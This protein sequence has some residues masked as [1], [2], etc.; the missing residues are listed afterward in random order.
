MLLKLAKTMSVLALWM[1]LLHAMP[2][3]CDESNQIELGSG[4]SSSD[5]CV[6][7]DACCASSSF[8]QTVPDFGLGMLN[9]HVR[10]ILIDPAVSFH[11]DVNPLLQVRLHPDAA[12]STLGK[13]NI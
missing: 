11:A 8:V 12:L 3:F 13:L 2:V 9:L 5:G 6:P 7:D 10:G 1:M 4:M